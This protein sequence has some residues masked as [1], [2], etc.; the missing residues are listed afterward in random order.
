MSNNLTQKI[1]YIKE[2]KEA[3]IAA[4][5]S[6]L[7]SIY[8][9]TDEFFDNKIQEVY[10]SGQRSEIAKKGQQAILFQF[11]IFFLTQTKLG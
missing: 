9:L 2:N 3:A 11:I 7:D 5:T 10:Y 4:L 1:N 6:Y 8:N